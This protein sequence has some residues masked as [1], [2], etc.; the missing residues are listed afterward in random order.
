MALETIHVAVFRY[1]E[2]NG[3]STLPHAGL[4]S[5]N[6]TSAMFATILTHVVPNRLGFIKSTASR[7]L[8]T[9]KSIQL[10]PVNAAGPSHRHSTKTSCTPNDVL[11]IRVSNMKLTVVG[12]DDETI[13]GVSTNEGAIA[14]RC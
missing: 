5:M 1:S 10:A 14:G 3:T 4:H 9:K 8:L 13:E 11:R 12:I 7:R 2:T 6:T